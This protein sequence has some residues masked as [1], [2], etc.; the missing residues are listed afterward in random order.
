MIRKQRHGK[1]EPFAIGAV[2]EVA[3]AVEISCFTTVLVEFLSTL[4]PLEIQVLVNQFGRGKD[5]G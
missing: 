4:I 3:L 1:H 2:Y 5:P